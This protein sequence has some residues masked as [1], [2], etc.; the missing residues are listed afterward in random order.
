MSKRTIA[1][2]LAALL[3]AVCALA[4]CEAAPQPGVAVTR[5]MAQLRDTPQQGGNV[6]MTYYPGVRV[7]V[8]RVT[9]AQYAQVNVGSR[10]GTLTG[11]MRVSDLAFTEEAARAVR[12]VDVTCAMDGL[13]AVYS[14]MDELSQELG[15]MHSYYAVLGVSEGGW[16]H[17]CLGWGKPA[18]AT[19]FVYRGADASGMR[20]SEAT[21]VYTLPLEGELSREEAVRI[22][23]AQI[24]ADER[25]A[26]GH[27]PADLGP[28]TDEG[29]DACELEFDVLSYYDGDLYY[30]VFF[31]G[32]AGL[33]TGIELHV[34]DGQVVSYSY[35]NG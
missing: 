29:M 23:R 2:A 15:R 7:E 4:L 3:T 8:V 11:Y 1:L 35:G 6:L 22:A 9:D 14:Y 26:Y 12:K 19:G 21:Y 25:P 18:D 13:P 33:Y 28:A 27:D 20:L 30:H 32:A 17:I 24:L 16:L 5:A 34:R 31:R 10:P